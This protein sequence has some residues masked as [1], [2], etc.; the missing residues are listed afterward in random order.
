[1]KAKLCNKHAGSLEFD[2][3]VLVC[4]SEGERDI[5]RRWFNSAIDMVGKLEGL[6]PCAVGESKLEDFNNPA[7]SIRFATK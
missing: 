5:M 4:E 6:H 3:I 2:H 7:I 1:M